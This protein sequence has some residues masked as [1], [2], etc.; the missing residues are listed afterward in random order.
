M[1]N[2][3]WVFNGL[4][5]D[6]KKHWTAECAT[7]KAERDHLRQVLKEVYIMCGMYYCRFEEIQRKIKADTGI[8]DR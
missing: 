1:G 7:V 8:D 6:K 4:I 2:D 3:L 5:M